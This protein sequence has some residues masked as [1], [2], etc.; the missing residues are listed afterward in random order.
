MCIL[1]LLAWWYL[2]VKYLLLSREVIFLFL[3][4]LMVHRKE[5]PISLTMELLMGH[6]MELLMDSLMDRSMDRTINPMG[7]GINNLLT[8]Q[9]MAL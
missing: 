1:G 6:L 5:F 4:R 3:D 8:L 2:R 9:I 7:A